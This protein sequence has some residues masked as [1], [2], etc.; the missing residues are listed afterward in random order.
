VG[1]PLLVGG[2][3][4]SATMPV[5]QTAVVGAV[6]PHTVGKAS[7]AKAMIRA[8]GGV[9]GISILVAVLARAVLASRP[10]RSPTGSLPRPEAVRSWRS[11]GHRQPR[12]AGQARNGRDGGGCRSDIR[13]PTSRAA[14]G[15]PTPRQSRLA[16]TPSH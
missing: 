12:G 13:E 7:G 10:A 6:G 5:T 16:S 1:L 2:I 4:N 8:F 11:P 9:F 14:Q 15:R 3:G